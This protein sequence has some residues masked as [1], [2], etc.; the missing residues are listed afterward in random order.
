M[1]NPCKSGDLAAKVKVNGADAHPLWAWMKS[2][3]NGAGSLTNDIKWNFTKFLLDQN[4]QVVA[5][6][7]TATE[8][9]KLAPEI[10]KLLA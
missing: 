4:G 5:R 6:L 8:M 9:A 2:Q 7:G 10:A 1:L 3:P